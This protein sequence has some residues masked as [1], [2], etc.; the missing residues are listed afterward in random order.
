MTPQFV[1]WLSQ[2]DSIVWNLSNV[3]VNSFLPFSRYTITPEFV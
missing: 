1:N 3:R 2:P